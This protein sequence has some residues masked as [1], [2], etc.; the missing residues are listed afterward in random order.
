ML[1]NTHVEGTKSVL[2][3]SQRY[4]RHTMIPSS[5][6]MSSLRDSRVK[7]LTPHIL[8]R[9]RTLGKSYVLGVEYQ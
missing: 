8:S 2:V 9:L 3:I 5:G 7:T 1:N 6:I 4:P